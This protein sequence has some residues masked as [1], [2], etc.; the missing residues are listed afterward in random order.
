MSEESEFEFAGGGNLGNELLNL[1]DA[2]D[3]EPGSA[4][5]YTTCKVIYLFHPLG[6]KMVD[7]PIKLAM[8]TPRKPV[9]ENSYGLQDDLVN[10]FKEEW[11]QLDA[12]AL[13]A[14]TARVAR[15][16]GLGSVAMLVDGDEPKEA[17][18]FSTIWR[19]SVSFNVIDPLNTAGSILL[20][21]NPNSP[22]F[23]HVTGIQ[24]AGKNY[25]KSRCHTIQNE[26]PIYLAFNPAS[27]GYS[28][29]SVYQRALYP[30][31]SFVQTMR[32]DDM[33][34]V[35]VGLLVTKVRQ[36]SGIINNAMRKLTG[37]KVMMLKRAKTGQVLEIGEND[38]IESL[39]LQN[40]DQ[41][42]S[43]ARR[44]ILENIAAACDMPA[45]LLNSETFAQGLAEGSEDAKA[46]AQYVD[47]VRKWLEPLYEFFVRVCQYRAWNPEFFVGLQQKY[48]DQLTGSY[49]SYFTDWVN[50]FEFQW[51]ESLKQSD[52]DKAK[53]EKVKFEAATSVYGLLADR[54]ANDPDNLAQLTE[55]LCETINGNKSLF[56]QNLDLDYELLAENFAANPPDDNTKTFIREEEGDE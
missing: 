23:Q 35:K 10:A 26:D 46:I 40:I 1:L 32:T 47:D 7:R 43:V 25:H 36:A 56:P 22:L 8:Y 51:D 18:D 27:F 33:V 44:N 17:V 6:G 9:I 12:D 39:N 37:F 50:Q 3:I 29:R 38:T 48:G 4:I 2:E 24:V 21:Q 5:G 41:P 55:W 13:I 49:S 52:A 45:M 16:Y 54:M 28:G 30:L 34:A 14:Q 53:E 15:I 20:D 19:Q 11:K 42:L 31:K